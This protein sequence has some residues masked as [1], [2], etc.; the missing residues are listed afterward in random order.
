MMFKDWLYKNFPDRADKIWHS[1]QDGHGGQ[2]NDSRFG[3]RMRGEGNL[4]EIINQ[5]FKK[6]TRMFELE[7]G[8]LNLNT[9]LFMRPGQ[10]LGLF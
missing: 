7:S 6:Y 5:Q 8:R 9:S 2:V 10:Q 1:I 4:A 3:V